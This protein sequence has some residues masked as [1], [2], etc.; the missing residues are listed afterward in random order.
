MSASG[1][2]SGAQRTG[3]PGRS[4]SPGRLGRSRSGSASGQATQSQGFDRSTYPLRDKEG[5]SKRLDLPPEAY[6]HNE[7][8]KHPFAKRPGFNT[9]GKATKVNVNQFRVLSIGN[10]D[11]YQY[12]L[13]ISPIPIKPI[14]IEKI[15]NAPKCQANLAQHPRPWIYDRR[16]LVWSTNKVKELRMTINIDEHKGRESNEKNTFHVILRN[17]GTIRLNS[18]R[19]YLNGEMDWD[20]SV[21]ECMNFLDHAIRETPTKHMKSIKRLF[22]PRDGKRADLTNVVEVIQGMYA[23][24]RMNQSIKEGGVGLGIN[25]N[26]AN[27]T[28]WLSQDFEQLVREY[29]RAYRRDWDQTD[30][31]QLRDMLKPVITKNEKGREL[32]ELSEAFKVITKLY[33]LKFHVKHRGKAEDD[34]EYTL[35]RFA[36]SPAYGPD[37]GHAKVYTFD[38]KEVGNFTRKITIFEY[39][40]ERYN[41]ELRMWWLPIVES[42]RGGAYPMEACYV[43]RYNRYPHRLTAYETSKMIK[44]AVQRPPQRFAD[45]MTKAQALSWNTDPILKEFGIK[46]DPNMAKVT[47]RLIPNPEIQF[48]SG[49]INPGTSGRWDLRGK[50]FFKANP[51]PLKS[52]A[53]VAV[54]KSIDKPGLQNFVRVFMTAYRS[55]GGQIEKEP[56]LLDYPAGAQHH[57]I[58]ED[59]YKRCGQANK[60][61]PQII[62]YV[63]MDRTSWIYERMKKNADCRWACLS[64][65]MIIDHVRK[66]Q[67]Q[68][69]SNIAMKVN[70]KL[71]GQTS[72]IPGTGSSSAFFKVPTMMIGVDV[73][74]AAPGSFAASMAAICCSMDKDGAYFIG[75]AE[76]NGRRVECLLPRNVRTLMPVPINMFLKKNGVP[77]KHV[78]YFRDG[79]SEGQFCHIMEYEIKALR[80]AFKEVAGVCPKITVIIAT[81]RHHIRFFPDKGFSDK[82]GNPLPGTLID[83]E[84]THPFQYDFYLCSHVA[85]QGTARPVHYHVI[86]D[87]VG[88]KPEELQKMIYQQCYQYM[89][90]TTPVSLHPAVYY[91]HLC[92]ARAR[93]H[94]NVA[95]SDQVPPDAKNWVTGHV[96]GWGAK[97]EQPGS[98][99]SRMDP[100]EAEPLL[101]M[102]GEEARADSRE[103]FQAG[104]WYI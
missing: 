50:K 4:N 84:V 79:V 35:K 68:Y 5:I 38:K 55:H 95:T 72:R 89:R 1:S 17:T 82:N 6:Y 39:F 101:P 2:A 78:F 30:Y 100:T 71:G 77:P 62:F 46:M 66:A 85:I 94:E 43:P 44:F 3:S 64:Q 87:E 15:W 86:H 20:T 67:P 27:V 33:R 75:T 48:G 8:T 12:D 99:T 93:Q 47:A 56:I 16:K 54:E 34:K 69:A 36:H 81:K 70:A 80:A 92:G 91:A 24:M 42:S 18:L 10:V 9:T 13:A 45:I 51:Q 31:Y 40:L 52:W 57:Y 60:A 19:A 23:S 96:P 73:S 22:F 63:L 65:M 29:I 61:T 98:L 14:I 7:D 58:C 25:V 53:F 32:Y 90:A 102:G 104:M 59:A 26:I 88:M 76:T 74:H 37:G 28:F 49:K 11:V 83:R 21:L 103:S 97:I 41:V